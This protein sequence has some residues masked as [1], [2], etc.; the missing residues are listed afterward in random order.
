MDGVPLAKFVEISDHVLAV[1]HTQ[2][3]D[4]FWAEL[5]LTCVVEMDQTALIVEVVQVIWVF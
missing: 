5:T 1:M 2:V 4:V 3:I